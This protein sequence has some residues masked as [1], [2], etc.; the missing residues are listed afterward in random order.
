M[1]I[2]ITLALLSILRLDL[3][4]QKLPDLNQRKNSIEIS[5]GCA[6]DDSQ[7]FLIIKD[8]SVIFTNDLTVDYPEWVK[9]QN[10]KKEISRIKEIITLD[11]VSKLSDCC[12][13]KFCPDAA[14][15]IWLMISK[16]NSQEFI[17]IEESYLDKKLC[18]NE[19]LDE[20]ITIFDKIQKNYR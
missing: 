9:I 17:T 14:C 19:S 3:S 13:K 12:T 5:Y 6:T 4:G 2:L 1:K 10:H 15:G 20:L 8:S 16:E 11:F 7:K 18:G